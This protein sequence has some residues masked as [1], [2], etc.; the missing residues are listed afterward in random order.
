MA[1]EISG[2]V[3]AI[4]DGD[5]VKI[6]LDSH[7]QITVRLANIDAPESSCHQRSDERFEACVE[8]SQ[9][10]SKAARHALA[11][12]IFGRDVVLSLEKNSLDLSKDRYQR[13]VATIYLDGED[14]N[15][16]MV[17]AGYAWFEHGYGKRNLTAERYQE[18]AEA[19]TQARNAVSGLWADSNPVPSW[20]FRHRK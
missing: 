16:K 4:S 2:K 10:F 13:T 3:I 7:S 5:T 14:I 1:G 19:E 11:R 20:E 12:M 18:Y 17:R 15:Y 6:L 9:P 8:E